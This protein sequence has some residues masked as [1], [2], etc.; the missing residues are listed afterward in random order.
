[1]IEDRII[2]GLSGYGRAGKDSVGV[3]LATYG[4]KRYA[5]ADKLRDFLYALNPV[6]GMTRGSLAPIHVQDIVDNEGWETAKQLPEVTRLLQRCGTE[7][8][9]KVLWPTIWVD[10]TFAQI[11]VEDKKIAFT[12]V[13]FDHEVQTIRA[14]GGVIIRVE[15]PGQGPKTAPDGSVHLSETALDSCDFEHTITNDGSLEDLRDDVE[16]LCKMWGWDR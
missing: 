3:F 8:G 5:F 1:M 15:R 9:Q 11:T 6:V 12:D 2:I 13:R 16:E 7:A 4:F 10:A 14:A